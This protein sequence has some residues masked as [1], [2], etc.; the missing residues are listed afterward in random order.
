MER[1]RFLEMFNVVEAEPA[2]ACLSCGR[3]M[4]RGSRCPE[5]QRQKWRRKQATRDQREVRLYGSAAWARIRLE[6][7]ADADYA[8]D[9]RV[10]PDGRRCWRPA[11][12][13]GHII[14]LRKRPDLALSRSNLRAECRSH[15]RHA[16]EHAPGAILPA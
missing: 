11:E 6:V 5:C 16:Q 9:S 13:C 7:L 4:A 1:A 2:R 3:L 15:Q 10:E 12:S 14:P 8:C